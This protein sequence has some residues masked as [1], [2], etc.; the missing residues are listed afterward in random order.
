M[1]ALLGAFGAGSLLAGSRTLRVDH[2]ASRVEF[3]AHATMHSV[4][5]WITAWDLGLAWVDGANLPDTVVFTGKGPSMTTD[6]AK[7]DEE[8]HHWME[9]DA[10]PDIVWRLKSFSGPAESPV[11]EGELTLHGVTVPVAVPVTLERTGD[12]L[13]IDGHA[14]LDTRKFDLP[15]FRKFGLL[16]VAPEV[17]VSFHIAGTLE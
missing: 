9:H 3:V 13:T 16:S 7:R 8:M 2:G 6:H 14:T 5:G 1:A 15:V 12:R 17:S 10:R 4:E 11:A